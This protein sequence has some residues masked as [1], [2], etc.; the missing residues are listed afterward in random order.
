MF[1]LSMQTKTLAPFMKSQKVVQHQRVQLLNWPAAS[2]KNA[3][4]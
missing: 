2:I 3:V 1:F 4:K